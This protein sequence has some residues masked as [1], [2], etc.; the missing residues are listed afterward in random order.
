MGALAWHPETTLHNQRLFMQ[1]QE[2][3]QNKNKAA[4]DG[5]GNKP[6]FKLVTIKSVIDSPR[7][8]AWAI[9]DI[10]EKGG[11]SSVS[12]SYGC[13]KSFLTYDQAFCVACGID[14][15]GHKVIQMP[16]II[17]CGEGHSGIADRFVALSIQYG[18]DVPDCL[19]VSEVAAALTDSDNA[20]LVGDAVN[21]VCPEAG[22]VIVDTLNRNF[23]GLDENSTRDMSAFVANIDAVFRN[24]GKTVV[25]VHHSGHG[26]ERGRGSSVLPG[27]CEAEFFIKKQDKGLVLN[28]TKQKNAPEHTPLQFKF[29]T[30]DLG[31]VDDEGQAISS[32]C[33]ELTNDAGKSKDKDKK[34]TVRDT[35]LLTSLERAIASKGINPSTEIMED[36]NLGDTQKIVHIDHWRHEAYQSVTVDVSDDSNKADALKKAFSR[37]REKL[38]KD[39]LI[40]EHGDYAWIVS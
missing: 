16:V 40:I 7:K 39:G 9:R 33:I 17:I 2:K 4:N 6:Q 29:K 11:T 24:S 1:E 20:E 13:G 36:F 27:A 38:F 19:Y 35:Q 31:H 14:W 28:C 15:H 18:V 26:S 3:T 32:L 30:I 21:Q 22:M 25:V 34:L 8:L 10:Y 37:G 5:D 23:G 12:G